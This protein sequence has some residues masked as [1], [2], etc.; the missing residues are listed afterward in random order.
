MRPMGISASN[1]AFVYETNNAFYAVV[2]RRIYDGDN[3]KVAPFV[4]SAGGNWGDTPPVGK[5]V[6]IVER[7]TAFPDKTYKPA[8]IE[9][10]LDVK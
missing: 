9:D 10:W 5:P 6:P 3:I 2:S 7:L 8:V 1:Q 4:W